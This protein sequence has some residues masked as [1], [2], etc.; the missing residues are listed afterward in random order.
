MDMVLYT[1]PEDNL[2]AARKVLGGRFDVRRAEPEPESL[3]PLFRDCSAFLDASMKVPVT[4]EMIRGAEKLKIIVTAT[5]GANHIDSVA[6]DERGIPLMT[7]KG[8][9]EVL[10]N[11]TSA[12]EHSWLLLMACARRFGSAVEH[13]RGGGWNRVEFPGVMLRG[14]TLG[15]V[16]LGRI[17]SW[18]AR[19][20]EAFGMKVIGYDPFLNELPE[21][22]VKAET[23][24]EIFEGSDFVS[25]HVHLSPETEGLVG[26]DLIGR[27]KTGSILVNTSRGELVDEDALADAVSGGRIAGAG[28]D[29]LRGEPDISGNVLWKLSQTHGNVIITPHIGGFCPESVD[30]VVEFS[31][32]RILDYLGSHGN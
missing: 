28:V 27:M 20:A 30:I 5:T 12:A 1:G 31:A 7:L 19:Y 17:G 11:I 16:G 2:K 23:M 10:R 3:E 13:V 29:V 18:M 9:K 21:G 25:L 8:Q 14:K 6:L 32:K 24:E 15:L 22:V 4:G 26:S